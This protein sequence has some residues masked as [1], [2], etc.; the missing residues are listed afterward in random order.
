MTGALHVSSA[1]G[2]HY[3]QSFGELNSENPSVGPR[4]TGPATI[5]PNL[6]AQAI[7]CGPHTPSA[8]SNKRRGF[9]TNGSY[10]IIK[11]MTAYNYFFRDERCNIVQWKG[12]GLPSPVSDWSDEKQRALLCEHWFVDPVK[13]RR[14]HRKTEGKLGFNEYVT[15]ADESRSL[16]IELYSM[17]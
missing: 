7:V 1:T 6:L 8:T 2:G 5:D 17:H 4:A 10:S 12:E 14:L 15:G 11:P 9:S 16:P 13:G 3:V